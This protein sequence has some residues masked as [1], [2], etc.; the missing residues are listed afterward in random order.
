[1]ETKFSDD[2]YWNLIANKLA[3]QTKVGA[4]EKWSKSIIEN[5]IYNLIEKLEIECTQNEKKAKL[6]KVPKIRG[7]YAFDQLKFSYD[8]FRR[9]FITR[10]SNG[11]KTTKHM[12]AI[13]LGY[14]SYLEF[15]HEEIDEIE[16]ISATSKFDLGIYYKDGKLTEEFLKYIEAYL[17]SMIGKTEEQPFPEFS[18]SQVNT[19]EPLIKNLFFAVMKFREENWHTASRCF[20]KCQSLFTKHHQISFMAGIAFYNI[21]IGSSSF[22]KALYYFDAAIHNL[23]LEVDCD[24]KARVFTYK[25]A[26]LK[27]KRDYNQALMVTL[28]G[29]SFAEHGWEKARAHYNLAGIY[30]LKGDKVGFVESVEY[31]KDNNEK[32]FLQMQRYVKR[33]APKYYELIV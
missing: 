25:G 14:D 24:I 9:I 5:F 7:V 32:Y 19:W 8:S 22:D 6:C 2:K 29:L 15:W 17:L 13:F 27:R 28:K 20:E 26:I 3:V 30:A 4:P 23:S 31:L 1:M 18:S 10:E 12:F 21:G 16:G 11:N 33:W